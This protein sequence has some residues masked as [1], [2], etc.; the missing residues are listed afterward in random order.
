MAR[1]NTTLYSKPRS[2][3]RLY[4]FYCDD[5]T[6][7]NIQTLKTMIAQKRVVDANGKL[8]TSLSALMR[9]IIKH[10]IEILKEEPH[11]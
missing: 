2:S 1:I 7:D 9:Y 11:E 8:I 4:T 6:F 10:S 5:E 3:R